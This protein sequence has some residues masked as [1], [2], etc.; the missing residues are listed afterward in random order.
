M[1]PCIKEICS[2]INLIL[3][4]GQIS[5]EKRMQAIVYYKEALIG[6]HNQKPCIVITMIYYIS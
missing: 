2:V 4:I 6:D 3:P 1:K 5:S